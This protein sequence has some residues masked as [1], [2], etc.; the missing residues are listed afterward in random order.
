MR[1]Y[2]LYCFASLSDGTNCC[3]ECE[4]VTA[5]SLRREFW[6]LKPEH[7]AWERWL[8][9]GVSLVAV[10]GVVALIG[11]A[12]GSKAGFLFALPF[13][14][15]VALWGT[16]SKLTR[17]SPHFRPSLVWG[18][19][20]A[21]LALILAAMQSPWALFA[22]TFLGVEIWACKCADGWKRSLIEGP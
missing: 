11:P 4:R 16:A 17:H 19:S 6:S 7:V 8:K 18:V 9:G 15:A 13:S 10:A 2:C 22:G 3:D 20:L 1:R 5:P 14:V 21:L 12:S